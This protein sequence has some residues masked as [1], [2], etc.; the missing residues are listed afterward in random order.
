MM[1]PKTQKDAVFRVN[2]LLYSSVQGL[3]GTDTFYHVKSS[4]SIAD[5]V[6][7]GSCYGV[8]KEENRR[9]PNKSDGILFTVGGTVPNRLA[10]SRLNLLFEFLQGK[11]LNC[12]IM[13]KG[14]SG[15]PQRRV[16]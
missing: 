3:R 6:L 11:P 13:Q 16:L 2:F 4:C 5:T 8:P 1:V 14:I 9:G 15:H 10:G 12:E 7:I